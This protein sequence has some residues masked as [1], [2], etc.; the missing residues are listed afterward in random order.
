MRLFVAALL[1]AASAGAGVWV[2]GD[3]EIIERPRAIGGTAHPTDAQL[4]AHGIREV[5]AP[6][7]VARRFWVWTGKGFDSLP[8]ADID[9]T[10][11]AEAQAVAEAQAAADAAASLPQVFPTGIA[12]LDDEGHHI[13]LVPD[14][15]D[16][17]VVPVQISNSPL[18]AKDRDT[19]KAAAVAARAQAKAEKAALKAE[20]KAAKNDKAKMDAILKWIEAQ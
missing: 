16:W 7:D 20:I 15:V 10:L 19:L 14:M 13:E 3:G 17:V 8:Q 11:A 1:C 9:A 18:T 12:T 6:M 5:D 2:Q 4:L